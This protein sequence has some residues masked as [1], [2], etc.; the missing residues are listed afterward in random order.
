MKGRV[1]VVGGRR[2]FREVYYRVQVQQVQQQQQTQMRAAAVLQ[3][4]DRPTRGAGTR[5]SESQTITS[6]YYLVKKRR[7]AWTFD[8]P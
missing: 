8:H 3:G 1:A 4:E 2:G 7:N 5:A 6:S